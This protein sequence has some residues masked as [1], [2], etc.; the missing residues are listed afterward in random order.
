MDVVSD[1]GKLAYLPLSR[2]KTVH[3]CGSD[4]T[5]SFN[6]NIVQRGNTEA[7]D[8]PIAMNGDLKFPTRLRG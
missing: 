8:R 5:I 1:K 3:P 7:Q 6:M 2:S 4:L